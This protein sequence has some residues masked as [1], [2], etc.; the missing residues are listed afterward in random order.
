MYRLDRIAER[1]A[2]VVFAAGDVDVGVLAH[3]IAVRRQL[4][5]VGEEDPRRHDMGERRADD[6][7]VGM[8]QELRHTL[9]RQR[10][11]VNCPHPLDQRVG[12][13]PHVLRIGV[14]EAGREIAD[15]ID[16]RAARLA[17]LIELGVLAAVLAADAHPDQPE[18]QGADSRDADRDPVLTIL[19]IEHFHD[20]ERREDDRLAEP[21]EEAGHAEDDF[22]P[23]DGRDQRPSRLWTAQPP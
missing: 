18:Q 8:R 4:R 15:A 12:G 14:Q 6:R 10:R 20:R 21:G 13:A 11:I 22:D 17:E 1:D 2:G 23:D 7:A 16:A 9:E 5:L 19:S 3:R